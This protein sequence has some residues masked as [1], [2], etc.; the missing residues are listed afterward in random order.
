MSSTR[1]VS[2]LRDGGRHRAAPPPGSSAKSPCGTAPWAPP[3][4]LTRRRPYL[5]DGSS[6]RTLPSSPPRRRADRGRETGTAGSSPATGGPLAI[7]AGGQARPFGAAVLAAGIATC[8]TSRAGV[9]RSRSSA[10]AST[11]SSRGSPL[12]PGLRRSE[13]SVLRWPTAAD[14]ADGVLVTRTPAGRPKERA[15]REWRRP[16]P[17]GRKPGAEGPRRADIAEDGGGCS[18]RRRPGRAASGMSQK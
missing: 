11:S 7:T 2:S 18:S 3:R 12:W 8:V 4:P 9:G 16:R 15:V 13:V 17:S 10:A 14:A 1:P 5:G 6:P